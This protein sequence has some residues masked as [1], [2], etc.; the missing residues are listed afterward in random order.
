MKINLLGFIG[1]ELPDSEKMFT[2]KSN[3]MEYIIEIKKDTGERVQ[4]K[5]ETAKKPTKDEMVDEI[6][7]FA[8]KEGI[9]P[10]YALEHCLCNDAVNEITN[11]QPANGIRSGIKR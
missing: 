5:W 11:P 1:E 9:C 8:I 3:K 6:Q 7:N 2:Q 4:A 10:S